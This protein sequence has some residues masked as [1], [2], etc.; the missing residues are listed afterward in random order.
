MIPS[1]NPPTNEDIEV[2]CCFCRNLPK[3]C[4]V[5]ETGA[6]DSTEHIAKSIKP[7]GG[8]LYTIDASIKED[9]E[10]DNIVCIS[11]WSV[12]YKDLPKPTDPDF[13]KS[14]YKD[15]VDHEMVFL[16]KEYMPGK[17]DMIRETVKKIGPNFDMFFCDTG[18]YCGLP[19]FRILEELNFVKIGGFFAAHDIYYPKSVKNYRTLKILKKSDKWKILKQTKTQQ[20]LVIAERLK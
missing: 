4:I 8:K 5:L 13:V 20:G 9:K 7:L 6:G 17:T 2:L 18:E 15:C 14:K 19:E 16:G 3:N 1:I 12:S 11:G 10:K